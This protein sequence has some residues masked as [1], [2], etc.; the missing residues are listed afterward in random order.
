[1]P[2]PDVPHRILEH[3]SPQGA[4]GLK[5]MIGAAPFIHFERAL[6]FTFQGSTEHDHVRIVLNND[7]LYNI[8]FAKTTVNG[9]VDTNTLEDVQADDLARV[10]EDTTGLITA[11]PFSPS[12]RGAKRP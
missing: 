5:L 9:L 4:P 12:P 1:M 11:L 2:D 8:H 6:S 7:D 3:L 10:F